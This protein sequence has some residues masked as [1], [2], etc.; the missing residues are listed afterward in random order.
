MTS[1]LSLQDLYGQLP[2]VP[3][4]HWHVG[5]AVFAYALFKLFKYMVVD[6]YNSPLRELPGPGKVDNIFWGHFPRILAAEGGL[7]HDEWFA[8]YGPTIQYRGFLMSRRVATIDPRALAHF[9]NHAYD[10]PKPD[11]ARFALGRVVG[12][13]VLSVEDDDHR[14]QRKIMNPCF[15]PAQIRDL[16]PIFYRKAYELRDIWIDKIGDAGAVLNTHT[17]L[18]RTTLDI[19]GLAGF[20]Y[21]F[22]SLQRGETDEL[23]RAL[24][25][26]FSPS[27][28]RTEFLA[29][30]QDRFPRTIGL[31]PSRR[32]K[33]TRHSREVVKRISTQIF[34]ERRATVLA[35]QGKDGGIEK[36]DVRARDMLNIMVRANMA[37]DLKDSERLTDAEVIDQIATMIIAGHE[38]TSTTVTW[39]L[40]ELSKAKN[41]HMQE[42]L[43]EELLSLKSD[44]PTMDELNAL[45]YLDA[46][47]REHL[48]VNSVIVSTARCASKDDVVPLSTPF[49][50]RN[51]VEH[52][53]FRISKGEPIFIPVLCMNRDKR[54]W[55]ED[56]HEFRPER[57]L[58]GDSHP[59]SAEIPG[60][61][62]GVMTFLGGPRACIGYRMALMEMKALIFVLLRS[63]S[64]ELSDPNL[65]IERKTTAVVRPVIKKE[66]VRSLGRHVSEPI[67]R[68]KPLM[69]FLADLPFASQVASLTPWQAGGVVAGAVALIPVFKLARFFIW[70]Y[71]S[72]LKDLRG[73]ETVDS[74]LWGHMAKIQANPGGVVFEEWIEKYGLT[75]QFRAF[76]QT[77]RL[78]TIDPRAVAYIVNHS[79]EFPRPY[80]F[81]EGLARIVGRGLFSVEGEDHRRQRRIMN[82]CFGPAQIRDLMPIFYEKAYRV[83]IRPNDCQ[84]YADLSPAWQLKSVWVDV[85]EE[86][87]PVVDILVG[88]TRATLDIIG[89][90]GF[91][92]EFDSL[93]V[94]EKNELIR[95]FVDILAPASR[96]LAIDFLQ[97][98]F[99]PLRLIPTN[100]GN[101]IK[102]GRAVISR[103]CTRIFEDKKAAALAQQGG[104]DKEEL[105]G[106]DILSIL[107][108]ANLA[109]DTKESDRMSDQEVIDQIGSMIL[110]GHE[111]SSTSLTWMLHALSKPE[112]IRIQDKLR[113]ELLAVDNERPSMD[114]LNALPYLDAVIRETLR[115][116]AVVE[117]TARVAEKD[118]VIPVSEPFVDC[119][120]V[121]RDEIRIAKGEIVIIP[122][123]TLNRH[124]TIW[125]EDG[126]EFK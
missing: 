10:F 117:S 106:R 59:R 112:N 12:R 83:C 20:D 8:Q 108:R 27:S 75:I 76:L 123:L 65:K 102:K 52:T 55:G 104:I 105:V 74:W 120:G 110:A 70:W 99:P 4:T 87:G 113:A 22:D 80:H 2:H 118:N 93:L 46:I 78:L 109:V 1:L 122:I 18:T 40:Y 19:I 89:S 64:F 24:T 29:F 39:L 48:R 79:V 58:T 13:G 66:D 95:S 43:R 121:L 44:E 77:R 116:D 9:I 126:G 56:A 91:S 47:V 33:V 16:M 100:R 103:I 71:R 60:V 26:L 82:P 57:W 7:V 85:V 97:G 34:E 124:P 90:A 62:A 111:T 98:M 41:T 49:L 119:H 28:T 50:D 15:G 101:A 92:Y 38:T 37:S 84:D 68:V 81:R 88:M 86:K 35:S 94:G 67:R 14:R 6:P 36:N 96:P 72:P 51:G 54:I 45:P 31:V 107:V 11:M 3:I 69:D 125:G 115:L 5:G 23:V 25:E 114:E 63:I 73:P 30:L 61:F 32:T 21:D 42:K 17:W 53:E